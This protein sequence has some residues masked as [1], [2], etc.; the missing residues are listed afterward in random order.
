MRQGFSSTSFNAVLCSAHGRSKATLECLPT[1]LERLAAQVSPS[2]VNGFEVAAK[3]VPGRSRAEVDGEKFH[4]KS[5][6]PGKG[7]V[8]TL[9][10]LLSELV[11]V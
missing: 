8:P 9:L 10:I 6:D 3:Q 4:R 2:M 5:L 11:G 1:L 7:A